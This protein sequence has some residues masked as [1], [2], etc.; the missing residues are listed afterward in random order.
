M[1][2]GGG[3]AMETIDRPVPAAGEVL[4]DVSYCG[5]CGSDLHMLA[6]PD[7]CPPGHVLP[8]R[9]IVTTTASLDDAAALLKDL[10]SG[11]TEQVKVLLRPH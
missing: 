8:C 6:A 4:L 9:Q 5:I 11:A 2:A 7:R 10:R 1:T 3:V